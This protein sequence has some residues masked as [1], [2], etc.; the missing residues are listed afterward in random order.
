MDPFFITCTTCRSRLKVRD[1][2]M[3][4]QILACPNCQAMVLVEPPTEG[5]LTIGRQHD[6]DSQAITSESIQDELQ[7]EGSF[8]QAGPP[9]PPVDSQ[10]SDDSLP[11]GSFGTVPPGDWKPSSYQGYRRIGLIA[12]VSLIAIVS[13]AAIFG[14]FI[15]SSLTKEPQTAAVDNDSADAEPG[16]DEAAAPAEG[17]P[18]VVDDSNTADAVDSEE[19]AASPT[20]LADVDATSPVP[21]PDGAAPADAPAAPEASANEAMV[22]EPAT[23]NETPPAAGVNQAERIFADVG[24]PADQPEAAAMEELPPSLQMFSSIFGQGLDLGQPEAKPQ[25]L[26]V[27]A[28]RFEPPPKLSERYPTPQPAVDAQ[29]RLQQPLGINLSGT[30]LQASVAMISQLVSVPITLDIE[31]FDSAGIDLQSPVSGRYLNTTAGDALREILAPIGCVLLQSSPGQMVVRASDARIA[32]FIEPALLVTDLQDPE[33]ILPMATQLANLPDDPVELTLDPAT[34][35]VQVTGSPQAAWRVGLAFDALRISRN[36]PPKLPATQT[37]R[38]LVD[39]TP[40]DL[41]RPEP[42]AVVL[43]GDLP[44]PVEHWLAQVAAA[45]NAR[46]LIDWPSAWQYGMTPEYTVLPWPTHETLT[47]LEQELLSPFGL[48]IRDL[49][50]G[51]WLVTSLYA[52]ALSSRTVVFSP[53]VPAEANLLERIAVAAGYESAETFAGVIDPVSR[54]LITRAPQFLQ[55]QIAA[56]LS[57]NR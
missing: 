36:L 30:T 18:S 49:G 34:S 3:L 37:S 40:L 13:S 16:S 21:P 6:I 7:S 2:S 55:T 4:G 11:A 44:R 10:D 47:S 51:N 17:E 48:T 23:G 25:P 43:E 39:G 32:S 9:Q 46:V 26:A 31:S 19:P 24:Q 38:W 54:R 50:D 1:E 33:T 56:E 42:G 29:Q 28:I 53:A 5:Q 15:Q 52:L 57:A 35:I 27:K 41:P 22:A 12:L 45:R 20:T 14:L 8:P